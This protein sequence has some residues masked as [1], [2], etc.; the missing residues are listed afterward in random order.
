MPTVPKN[1]GDPDKIHAID[2]LDMLAQDD[3]A[4]GERLRK[5][6]AED[7]GP[8][9]KQ[10]L[11]W[12]EE[13]TGEWDGRV[14]R[15]K[16]RYLAGRIRPAKIFEEAVQEIARK[17]EKRRDKTYQRLIDYLCGKETTKPLDMGKNFPVILKALESDDENERKLAKDF[18]DNPA[19]MKGE[20]QFLKQLTQ[21]KK[22]KVSKEDI[23]NA[24][25]GAMNL[26]MPDEDGDAQLV[27]EVTAEEQ[28]LVMP[29]MPEEDQKAILETVRKAKTAN[30]EA[31]AA[32]NAVSG[33]IQTLKT[34][35]GPLKEKLRDPEFTKKQ[36]EAVLR[37]YELLKQTAR[38]LKDPR[39]S[40]ALAAFD[41]QRKAY[42]A[43]AETSAVN[44]E[45][46]HSLFLKTQESQEVQGEILNAATANIEP[47]M[48]KVIELEMEREMDGL[49][50]DAA[51]TK[52]QPTAEQVAQ[53][54]V[55]I[56]KKYDLNH[57]DETDIQTQITESLSLAT[58]KHQAKIEATIE[59]SKARTKWSAYENRA[60]NIEGPGGKAHQM[61]EMAGVELFSK[62]SETGALVPKVGMKM[63]VIVPKATKTDADNI[64][65]A[66]DKNADG[67]A[68]PYE[69][70]A[71]LVEA[72]WEPYS[73]EEIADSDLPEIHK[74]HPENQ[75]PGRF[76]G[77]VEYADGRRE[78]LHSLKDVKGWA[79]QY[80]A[81][82][83]IEEK[84]FL[85]KALKENLGFD[86]RIEAG[87]NF[88]VMSESRDPK[89]R[90][91]KKEY[92]LI[93][94]TRVDEQ[95][96]TIRLNKKIKYRR[97]DEY[98]DSSSIRSDQ[99][100]DILTYGEF[101]SYMLRRKGRISPMDA[102]PHETTQAPKTTGTL[103][104]T[105][106]FETSLAADLTPEQK[107]LLGAIPLMPSG[108]VQVPDPKTGRPRWIEQVTPA[109][110]M[111]SSQ[112]K[113]ADMLDAQLNENPNL[114]EE[115]ATERAMQQLQEQTAEPQQPEE[116]QQEG[117]PPQKSKDD[118]DALGRHIHPEAEINLNIEGATIKQ[119]SGYLGEL[120]RRTRFMGT[121]DFGGLFKSMYE[122]YERNWH[123]RSKEKYASV[124]EG[125]P[126]FGT[127]MGRVKQQAETEEVNQFMEG[128]DDWGEWDIQ[129]TLQTTGS[130][131]R[132]KACFSVL[133]KKGLIRWD[134]V[135]MW[136]TL[137]KLVPSSI[138]IP[139]PPTGDPYFKDKL[140]QK[141]GFEYIEEAID[142]LWGEGTYNEWYSGNN[143]VY[144]QKLKEYT[145]KGKHL[146]GDPKNTGSVNGEL[147][148]L[149][150]R[151][152]AGGYVDPHEYEGL[153]HFIIGAGKGSGLETKLYYIIQGVAARNPATGEA[154]MSLDRLGSINGVYL[155]Q[156]PIMDYITRKD[157][158]RGD[159]TSGPW[160]KY[161]YRKW[162]DKWDAAASHGQENE[163]NDAVR[164]HLWNYV[165]TDEKT[166]IRNNKGLRKAGDMD[167]D[168]AYAI[169]PLADEELI[170]N[171]CLSASGNTK[172]FTA[173]GY[174]N[175]YPGFNHY[176]K[177]LSE[178]GETTKL[179]TGVKSFVK[180]NSIM[181]KR[182]KKDDSKY[183]RIGG[184]FWNR[185]SVVDDRPTGW[186]KTQMETLIKNI[187]AL[188]NDEKLN[189]IVELMHVDTD[190]TQDSTAKEKQNK[191]QGALE[192][193][194][195]EFDRVVRT[196]GGARM[197]SATQS[198]NL[199]GMGGAVSPQERMMRQKM[200][201]GE[202]DDLS[203]TFTDWK[204]DDAA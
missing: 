64:V 105:A 65:E 43:S 18:I 92:D 42:S 113:F 50:I 175:A 166:I 147:K 121:D 189:E 17:T 61:N 150:E 46:I 78:V 190:S 119:E 83:S 185:P 68:I 164:H 167:H 139:I 101:A 126:W 162:C 186:H 87:E 70:Q 5:Q 54:L 118:T 51:E 81:V 160:T 44:D 187:A 169:I 40:K 184:S 131:D 148:I 159:G 71:T 129:E 128:M 204:R 13:H 29:E 107:K 45:T 73:D 192:N 62:D 48:E 201:E 104:D 102:I 171:I 49:M 146:E 130:Q 80:D 154:I 170:E 19:G 141:T 115:D 158:P 135:K 109:P 25:K 132:V 136:K 177:T 145:E 89:T 200:F 6:R 144:D 69:S 7:S 100:K 38:T 174:A 20:R 79:T 168:D 90:E 53:K 55:E 9:A 153:L 16:E 93:Q 140:T 197:V 31:L 27:K 106:D 156:F 74:H 76:R 22:G 152:K 173:E 151:H 194:S 138:R 28:N 56:K 3:L 183:A 72:T 52:T 95:K 155:N 84:T 163:P 199:S 134:D 39:L 188:Y 47:F 116:G 11:K 161:D 172:F 33:H 41:K 66:L 15:L 149:L 12:C 59:L 178:K 2:G 123:R 120:W 67:R 88:L 24:T 179:L 60:S 96:G 77:V 36:L 75:F 103:A 4:K 30:E 86:V 191:V 196:D 143:N 111:M 37:D 124:G 91:M 8:A 112:D 99:S 1:P 58:T 122:Y 82:E 203:R 63:D 23:S 157:V 165:L 181:S 117:K 26:L 133:A 97:P 195:K 182:W 110:L 21:I 10:S 176:F 14:S 198:A 125:L 193:F 98:Y 114:S 202:N 34:H 35:K 127:E 85:Q 57:E 108:K 94:I 142:H 32:Q 180:F 137:N